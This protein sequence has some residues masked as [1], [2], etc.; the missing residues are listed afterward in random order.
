MGHGPKPTAK[1]PN[2]AER[3]VV[4]VITESARETADQV[5]QE[6]PT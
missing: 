6:L 3:Q 1:S 4:V 2:L 5:E